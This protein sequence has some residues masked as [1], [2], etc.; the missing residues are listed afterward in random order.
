MTGSGDT[1]RASGGRGAL[2]PLAVGDS[3]GSGTPMQKSAFK[4]AGFPP[5]RFRKII[6]SKTS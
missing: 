5:I 4:T 2:R 1:G 6:W 3:H